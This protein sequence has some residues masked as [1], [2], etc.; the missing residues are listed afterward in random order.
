MVPVAALVVHPGKGIA[1]RLALG[2]VRAPVALI[3]AD[4]REKLGGRI[5]GQVVRQPL[6]DQS[7]PEAAAHDQMPVMCD[8]FQMS[9]EFMHGA[10]LL[11]FSLYDRTA[12]GATQEKFLKPIDKLGNVW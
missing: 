10:A 11:F 2:G 4:A 12:P 5:L 7:H 6:P 1:V 3:I 8:R 9:P